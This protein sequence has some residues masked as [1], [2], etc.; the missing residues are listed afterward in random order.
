MLQPPIESALNTQLNEEQTAAQEYL[1]MAAWFEQ[2]VES[3]LVEGDFNTG[4]RLITPDNTIHVGAD[5]AYQIARD[6][7]YWRCIAWLYF[8]PGI[9]SLARALYAQIAANRQSQ[10]SRCDD[11]TCKP[12]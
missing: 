12:L 9:H 3:R 8:V 7:R 4:M 11:E 2:R 5:A 10:G 6:L 1:A